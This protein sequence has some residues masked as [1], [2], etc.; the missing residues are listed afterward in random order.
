M[1]AC[2]RACVCA[3]CVRA[4]VFV[5]VLRACVRVCFCVY[6]LRQYYRLED[7][8]GGQ[9]GEE[10]DC[11]ELCMCHGRSRLVCNVLDCLER[12]EC[13]SSLALYHH[14]TAGLVPYREGCICHHG[15]FICIR[16]P[17]GKWL[18]TR[19]DAVVRGVI[20]CA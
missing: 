9:Y 2:V 16:P 18:R 17:A 8:A 1:L 5:C 7:R 20:I 4:C 12:R 11:S 19:A 13:Q 6:F 14:G 10:K 15:D 3:Y